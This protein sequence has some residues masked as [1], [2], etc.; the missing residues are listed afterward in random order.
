[1]AGGIQT[2]NENRL[3]RAQMEHL[4]AQTEHMKA[5]A[6][7]VEGFHKLLKTMTEPKPGEPIIGEGPQ[8]TMEQ[9]P[10]ELPGPGAP[11]QTAM[12]GQGF[13]PE[14]LQQPTPLYGTMGNAIQDLYN[15]R[16]P[17]FF[18]EGPRPMSEPQTLQLEGPGA[19][20]QTGMTAPGPSQLDAILAGYSPEARSFVTAALQ[21][22]DPNTISAVMARV[23]SPV[24][25]IYKAF[26]PKQDIYKEVAGQ[27]PELFKS[28]EPK[29]TEAKAVSD[30]NRLSKELFNKPYNKLS[31][32]E[33]TTVNE[34]IKTEA[35]EKSRSESPYTNI[36]PD[37][38]RPDQFIGFNKQTGNI[39]P[40]PSSVHQ[41]MGV[42]YDT[43]GEAFLKQIDP[44]TAAQVKAL[45]E[46]RMQFPA[47]FALKSPY[48]QNMISLVSQ[49]DPT[50]DAVNYNARASTRRDFTSGVASRSLNALNTVMGHLENFSKTMESLNNSDNVIWNWMKNVT[51]AP[52]SPELK[53]KLNKFNID[54]QAVASEF[55]RAY[56]GAGGSVTDIQAWKNSFSAADSPQAM[57]G[58]LQEG[59]QLLGS[60]IDALG[61]TYNKGMGTTKEGLDLL[62]PHAKHAYEKL[63]GDL[64]VKNDESMQYLEQQKQKLREKMQSAPQR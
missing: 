36:Q 49:Y 57:R 5:Q 58:S 52:F 21:S 43:T 22:G 35:V 40:I 2:A 1:L 54:K 9:P 45:S 17:A 14:D 19:P 4:Q 8:P 16:S 48:W 56:R 61:D 34:R 12:P 3:H 60:K 15:K 44:K 51:A 25:P 62:A 18:S 7:Q 23:M 31:Q 30:E 37:P 63:S 42:H 27:P 11:V 24:Q 50:F 59:V 41:G 6:K 10:M 38:L 32:G 55:E 29:E 53:A 39:E 13:T 28:G 47:G 46:G 26:D 20:M 64:P 33:A